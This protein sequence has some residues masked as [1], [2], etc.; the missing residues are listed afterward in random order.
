M[1][2]ALE[3]LRTSDRNVVER[4]IE[5]AADL[6]DP[7]ITRAIADVFARTVRT[8]EYH[9]PW[10]P[11][12]ALQAR[13]AVAVV[14]LLLES[15]SA[16]RNV[17][18]VT[19]QPVA[20]PEG[21]NVLM[22]TGEMKAFR[23]KQDDIDETLS[24]KLAGEKGNA[25]LEAFVASLREKLKPSVHPELLDE[26]DVGDTQPLGIREGFPAAPPDPRERPKIL[27]PDKI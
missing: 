20:S 12:Q 19:P 16:R 18:A 17:G 21:F 3:D 10:E 9:R 5:R 24:E 7:R 13:S 22:W 2:E 26:I 15:L 1:D 11:L 14:P 25:A 23:M 27:A 4:A 8:D 6:D